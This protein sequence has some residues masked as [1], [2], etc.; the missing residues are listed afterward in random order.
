MG[1][2]EVLGG[3]AVC[4]CVDPESDISGR[5]ITLV[6][7]MR[8]GNSTTFGPEYHRCNLGVRQLFLEKWGGH[9]MVEVYL[10]PTA[11]RPGLQ[12]VFENLFATSC[13]QRWEQNPDIPYAGMGALHMGGVGS[14]TQFMLDLEIRKAQW[15]SG[16]KLD[17][18][19]ES[20]DFDEVRRTTEEKGNFLMSDH[21][22]RHFRELWESEY[23]RSDDDWLGDDKSIFEKCEE[24]WRSNLE[25]WEPPEWPEEKKKAMAELVARAKKEFEVD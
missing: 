15:V 21:T 16:R 18:N 11:R 8:N 20:M 3:M 23:L 1:A 2:A 6:A 14:P 9:C 19:E 5:M 13:R 22:L 10:G 7:D 4:W 12:A 25:K 17:V 24:A